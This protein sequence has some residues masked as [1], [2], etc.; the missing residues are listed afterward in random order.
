LEK[1]GGW[2]RRGGRVGGEKNKIKKRKVGTI[3]KKKRQ[4]KKN[5]SQTTG[6]KEKLLNK[7]VSQ[8]REGQYWKKNK[9]PLRKKRHSSKGK[10][11]WGKSEVPGPSI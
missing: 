4:T 8:S 7:S 11:E 9:L 5:K 2:G 10:G 3:K 6:S 1:G